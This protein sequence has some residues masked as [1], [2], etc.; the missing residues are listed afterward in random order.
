MATL[1]RFGEEGLHARRSGQPV[2]RR[3]GIEGVA[4]VLVHQVNWKQGSEIACGDRR[5]RALGGRARD[6]KL[7]E[8]VCGGGGVDSS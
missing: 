4:Q 6:R 3:S 7:A 2:A 1:D 5:C 8:Q